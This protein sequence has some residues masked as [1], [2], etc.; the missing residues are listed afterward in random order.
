MKYLV[1]VMILSLCFSCDSSKRTVN[2]DASMS[3]AP[4]MVYKTSSDYFYN[5]P[6]T[7]SEDKSRIVSYPHPI[8]L[9]VGYNY[10]T[11]TR[12][13]NGYLLD[14]RGIN[15]NVAFLRLTYEEY[16]KLESVLPLEELKS[17]VKDDNPLT[18]LY[19]CG[20]K[21]GFNNLEKQLNR[22]ILRGKLDEF[23]RLK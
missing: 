14:N 6:I 13:K 11:P 4:V 3:S 2:T 22:K 23:E 20:Y 15:S 16:V 8:D 1:S 19:F 7:L 5:V 9:L 12:L 10:A 18:E 21:S 17:M